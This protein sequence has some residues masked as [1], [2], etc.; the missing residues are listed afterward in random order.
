MPRQ[1]KITIRQGSGTP[2]ASAFATAEPAFDPATGKL[3]VKGA[4]GMVEFGGP[5]LAS[6]P[7][8]A[9]FPAT[10]LATVLYL[11]TDSSKIYQWSG[12]YVEVGVES[13]SA[14]ESAI[15]PFLLMGG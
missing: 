4:S 6:Y 9:S 8:S 12:V 1:N 7:T 3:W 13:G 5:T 10:G 2:T 15:H 11:A 14:T